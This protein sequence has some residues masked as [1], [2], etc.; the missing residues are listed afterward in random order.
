MPNQLRQDDSYQELLASRLE[1]DDDDMNT[2]CGDSADPK[3]IQG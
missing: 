1:R 3:A 2:N